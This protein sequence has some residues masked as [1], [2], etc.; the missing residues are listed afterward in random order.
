MLMATAARPAPATDAEVNAGWPIR[1]NSAIS[2]GFAVLQTAT[3]DVGALQAEWMKHTPGVHAKTTTHVRRNQPITTFITFRGCRADK[4]GKCDVTVA[5]EVI[6][7]SGKTCAR[8]SLDVW[9]HRPQPHAGTIQL[10]RDGMEVV[11]DGADAVGAYTVQATVTDH[12]AGIKLRTRQTITVS[13]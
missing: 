7:P 2:G 13:D 6:G 10:S 9:S 11:F 12:V 1:P 3:T 5:Y 4:A 8:Q